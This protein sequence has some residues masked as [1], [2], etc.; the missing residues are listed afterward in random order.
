MKLINLEIGRI[1][2]LNTTLR[3]LKPSIVK[4]A[5]S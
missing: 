5:R 4:K 2:R 1:I 3:E